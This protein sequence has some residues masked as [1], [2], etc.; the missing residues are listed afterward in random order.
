MTHAICR[1]HAFVATLFA[2]HPRHRSNA[3]TWAYVARAWSDLAELKERAKTSLLEV[4][5]QI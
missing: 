5:G 1:T 3:Q 4:D 2:V